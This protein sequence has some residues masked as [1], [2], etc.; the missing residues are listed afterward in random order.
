VT[1]VKSSGNNFIKIKFY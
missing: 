1:V